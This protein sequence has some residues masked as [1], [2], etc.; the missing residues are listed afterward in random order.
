[1][2]SYSHV[3]IL[4]AT[5]NGG[6]YLERQLDSIINQSY[7]NW[8]LFIRDDLSSDHTEDIIQAY[9]SKDNRI[10]QIHFGS[11]HGS[12]CRNFSQLFEWYFPQRNGYLM[13]ADQ[14]DIWL[15][16]KIE[17]SLEEMTKQEKKYGR[18]MPLLCYTNL[19]F[20]DE[21]D[22]AI[23]ARIPLPETLPLPV[24]LNENYAWGCTMI[25][26]Q[27]AISK[28]RHIPSESVNHDYFVALVVAAFGKNIRI[29]DAPILY[30]QHGSNVSGNISKMTFKGRFERYF[31]NSESMLKPLTDNYKLVKTFLS[32]Y[33][34]ELTQS[35]RE[36]IG[37]FLDGYQKNFIALLFTMFKHHIFKIGL[38]K[39]VIYLYTLL[40][41]RRKVIQAANASE[42]D[43][44]NTF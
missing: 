27:A 13:F 34:E 40:R 6:S 26:N 2:N 32:L 14:D 43:R 35:K 1:M 36:M 23:E 39:N 5:Y 22:K 29:N 7:A 30:R 38:T 12:A 20:I 21:N 19:Q 3:T 42:E 18:E 33:R 8:T 28:I 4:M 10:K 16:H 9:C 25:L 15:N 44:E 31:K 11:L 37:S 24:L 41:L 17:T